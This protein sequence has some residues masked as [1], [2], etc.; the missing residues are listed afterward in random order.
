MKEKKLFTTSDREKVIEEME[1]NFLEKVC[2]FA[3]YL[4]QMEVSDIDGIIISNS[5]IP[6][7]TFNIAMGGKLKEETSNKT[8]SRISSYFADKKLPMAW[9]FG[10]NSHHRDH[11]KNLERAGFS[12]DEYD[13]GMA[14]QLNQLN[15][16]YSYP[17]GLE[18]LEVKDKKE[19]EDFA[20]VLASIFTP[21][22]IQVANYYKQVGIVD[23]HPSQTM[24]LFIAYFKQKPVAISASYLSKSVAGI[25]DI[26]TTPDMQRKGFG[27]AMTYKALKY[28]KDKGYHIATLQASPDGINIYKRFGF[29]EICSFHVYGNAKAL[30]KKLDLCKGKK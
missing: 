7:D 17:K 27:S 2:Y 6:S 4:P 24:K 26:C 16:N 1:E 28:A 22:D 8:I 29:I 15:E 11:Q 12:Y 19:L 18:I 25:Y 13:V 5:N 23:F 3:S 21:P 10:P 9:W 30:E 14:M 20:F